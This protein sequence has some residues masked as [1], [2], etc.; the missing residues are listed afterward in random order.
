ME[1]ARFLTQS[2]GSAYTQ[3]AAFRSAVSRAYYAAFCHAR[4]YARDRQ[5]FY[6]THTP[7]DHERVRSH[8]KSK[9]RPD[10]ARDLEILRRWRNQC[11]YND[12]VFNVSSFLLA[13]L[14]RAQKII[15]SLK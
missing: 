13:A 14:A 4:N 3:E 2:A 15:D 7:K 11:D 5:G 9:G 12:A 1:L 6:P 8:F 10:I